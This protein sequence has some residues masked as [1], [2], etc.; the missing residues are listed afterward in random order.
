MSQN[1]GHPAGNAGNS[2]IFLRIPPEI[3]MS[4]YRELIQNIRITIGVSPSGQARY[5]FG[6]ASMIL[7]VS[8]LSRHEASLHV[9]DW[10]P[11]IVSAS[12]PETIP[13][14]LESTPREHHSL[15]LGLLTKLVDQKIRHRVK[16]I[17]NIAVR[18]NVPANSSRHIDWSFPSQ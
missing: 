9:W 1:D 3:G 15:S 16:H 14:S 18:R 7:Q 4:I 10:N 13:D 6:E 11:I 5:D 2:N 8:K 12:L 17:R